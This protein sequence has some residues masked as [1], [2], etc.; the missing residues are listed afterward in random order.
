MINRRI[1]YNKDGDAFIQTQTCFSSIPELVNYYSKNADELGTMLMYPCQVAQQQQVIDLSTQ[2]QRQWE[3]DRCEIKLVQKLGE[4]TLTEVWKGTWNEVIPVDV[5]VLKP[6]GTM[7]Q[8][9]FLQEA[10]EWV[11]T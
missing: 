8:E 10:K 6:G 5:K 9:E 1:K 2:V 4:G 3:M 11:N 7:S